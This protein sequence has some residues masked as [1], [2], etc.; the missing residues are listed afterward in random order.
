MRIVIKDKRS[1]SGALRARYTTD[2]K[3]DYP[4]IPDNIP[5]TDSVLE[6][7]DN[8]KS[9][10]GYSTFRGLQLDDIKSI[11]STV[12]R[13]KAIVCVDRMETAPIINY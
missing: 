4:G 10:L 1:R 12:K 5:L 13:Q 7:Y 9:P 3:I 2:I 11:L 8:T 6:Q